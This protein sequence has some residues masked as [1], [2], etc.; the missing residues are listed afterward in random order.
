[1]TLL[2]GNQ[3]SLT[4]PPSLTGGLAGE[5]FL[6]LT[7]R[8]V[9]VSVLSSSELKTLYRP[10]PFYDCCTLGQPLRNDP[11]RRPFWVFD[12]TAGMCVSHRQLHTSP[13]I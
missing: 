3:V 7:L 13:V 11:L 5:E 8:G 1:M 4:P 6:P 10:L 9:D 12:V 2:R